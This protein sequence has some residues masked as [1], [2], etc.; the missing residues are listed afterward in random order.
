MVDLDTEFI[1]GVAQGGFAES[2]SES[3]RRDLHIPTS[4]DEYLECAIKAG[5]Q[6]VLTGNPGDGKTQHILIEQEKR[7]GIYTEPDASAEADYRKVLDG[8]KEA[9]ENDRPGI[10]AINDG[11][12]DEII[13]EYRSEYDFL[14][15]VSDQ[16]RNQIVVEE[17]EVEDIDFSDIT[18]ID[19]NNREVLSE[20]FVDCAIDR[21]IDSP[22]LLT[23]HDHTD[24]CHIQYNLTHLQQD[25]VQ[26]ELRSRLLELGHLDIHITVRDLLNFLAYL[27]TGGEESCLYDYGPEERYYNLAY[28]GDGSLFD[29]FRNHFDVSVHTHPTVDDILWTKSQ[30]KVGS[31]PYLNHPLEEVF[32]DLKRRFIFGEDMSEDIA[33]SPGDMLTAPGSILETQAGIGSQQG[34]RGGL[35]RTIQRIN[36]YFIPQSPQQAELRLWFSHRYHSRETKSLVS[37][38]GI[39]KHALQ[40]RQPQFNPEVR[41]ALGELS[42]SDYVIQYSSGQYTASLTVDS[43]LNKTLRTMDLG[44][45]YVLRDRSEEQKLLRFMRDIEFK[46][47]YSESQATVTIKSTESGE[48]TSLRIDDDQYVI[49]TI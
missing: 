20:E 49:D 11:P 32:I 6:V 47:T 5:K 35:E 26:R 41:S 10:L 22:E 15:T 7:P 1:T 29:L 36:R 21:I 16:F 23:D 25:K 28:S 18:V 44:I 27:I 38:A 19:L 30:S 3:E 12:L 14:E 8:W 33:C 17:H 9:L 34:P 4:V 39:S 43:D 40:Q 37:R 42:T 31:P 24:R 48:T 45:P 13:S 2:L 46:E